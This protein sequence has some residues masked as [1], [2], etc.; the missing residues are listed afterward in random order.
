MTKSYD[1]SYLKVT[2]HHYCSNNHTNRNK[3]P[4][5]TLLLRKCYYSYHL[6]ELKCLICRSF[7]QL[8]ILYN[9]FTINKR[10][11]KIIWKT[12]AQEK[13][14]SFLHQIA[15]I[16]WLLREFIMRLY[17]YYNMYKKINLG[18]WTKLY[19]NCW[20]ILSSY[21]CLV[22]TLSP[23]PSIPRYFYKCHTKV[24]SDRKQFHN[25]T[26]K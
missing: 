13:N 3:T 1:S 23:S 15:Y 8:L 14:I 16:D 6:A 26:T 20:N 17:I 10:A 19:T 12:G 21:F 25:F 7:S 4:Q 22:L 5:K 24:Q 9:K 18:V 2:R 11:Y